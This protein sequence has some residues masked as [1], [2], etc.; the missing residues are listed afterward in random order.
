[1]REI[2]VKDIIEI[3]NAT[4][5]CGNEQ[6]IVKNLKK[7]TREIQ[8]GDTYVGIQG[9]NFNGSMFFEKAIENGAKICILDDIE[10]KKEIIEKYKDIAII[11]VKDTIEAMQKLAKVKRESYDIPVIGITGSVGKTSTKDIIASVMSKK[12][13]TLKTAGNYNN[14]I[15]LPLTILSLE[16]QTA[17]VIEMGMNH[18]GEIANLTKIARPTMSVIT[19]IRNV[20]YRRLRIKRKHIKSK[21]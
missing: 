17:A 9:E 8:K 18:K 2:K 14:H 21:T 6:E 16:N 20:T 4:L 1:M 3:C 12:Y 11:K 10:I 5:V 19:N 15:G 13:N 7:D